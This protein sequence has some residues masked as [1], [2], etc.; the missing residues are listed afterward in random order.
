MDDPGKPRSSWLDRLSAFLLREPED[1][2]ELVEQLHAAFERNLLDAEA[3]GMIE[4]VLS[5]SELTVR[6]VMIPRSQ[7]NVIRHTDPIEQVLPPIIASGHSRFPV[8]G[9]D[10]DD[11]KGILLAKDL[12]RYFL[13]PGH[14]RLDEVLRPAL[15]VPESKPLNLLL[16]EFRASHNHLALVVDEYGSVAGLATI[17]DVIEQIVGDIEDEFDPEGEDDII[18]VKGQRYRVNALTSLTDFNRYFDC[19]LAEDDIDTIGGLVVSRLG[20]VPKRG[21]VHE[22]G[23]LRFTVLKADSRRLFTLLVEK[24]TPTHGS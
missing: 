21:D 1:R 7:M 18:P 20:F 14:F 22:D 13:N 15:F 23:P 4:G 16:R 19:K 17:E 3:L 10:K 5:V 12:L 8:V 24:F 11:V 9:E 2:R 6:D